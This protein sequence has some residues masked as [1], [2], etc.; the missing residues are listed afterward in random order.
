MTLSDLSIKNP[1]FAWML[2][3]AMILFG[4]ISFARM[5][6]SQMP[7]VNF[8]V[9]T[10]NVTDLGASPETMET[11]VVDPIEGA[12]MQVEGVQDVIS[13]SLD[14]LATIT[15]TF[16]LDRDVDSGLADIQDAVIGVQKQLPT[17]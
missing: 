6:I 11:N 8:P 4:G 10:I 12:V 17:D 15:I 5:G 13:Q 7:D 16:A 9:V 3:F 1:V 2:M 14:G